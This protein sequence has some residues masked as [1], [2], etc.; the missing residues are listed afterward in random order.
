[1][2]AL[3]PFI[4]FGSFNLRLIEFVDEIISEKTKNS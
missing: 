4:I 2:L 3:N 1:M